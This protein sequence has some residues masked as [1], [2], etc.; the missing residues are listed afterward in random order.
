V[1]RAYDVDRSLINFNNGG[2]CPA[3]R[4]VLAA[5]Q[6]HTAFTNHQPSRHLWSVLDPQVETVR[7]RIALAFGCDA[8]EIA[9][10]RNA[11]EALEIALYGFDFKPGDEVLATD[12]DYP[13]MLNTLK[14]RELREG[15]VLKTFPF[16]TPPKRRKIGRAHV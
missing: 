4:T 9:I 13:R 15:I 7:K 10:T 2:V 6:R 11:S 8:E 5:V 12:H 3:P 14:Q 1:Q 16:P